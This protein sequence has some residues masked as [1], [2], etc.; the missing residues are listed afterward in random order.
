MRSNPGC[1]IASIPV[2][3]STEDAIMV[4]WAHLDNVDEMMDRVF[5]HELTDVRQRCA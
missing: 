2:V 5:F 3:E 1:L 4:I